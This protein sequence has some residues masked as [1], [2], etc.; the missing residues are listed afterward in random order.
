[1]YPWT[2]EHITNDSE[3]VYEHKQINVDNNIG[4]HVLVLL[5]YF[6]LW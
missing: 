1:M 4:D 2:R 5:K 6:P 3:L